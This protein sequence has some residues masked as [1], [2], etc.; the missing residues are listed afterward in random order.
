MTGFLNEAELAELTPS[1]LVAHR[2]P[3]PMQVVSSDEYYPAPQNER[4]REVERR[5]LSIADT[6]GARHG[7]DRRRFFQT[8]AGMTASFLAMNEV[9]GALFDATAA[10]AA[11]PELAQERADSLKD[12]LILDMHT[13][14][15]PM[16]PASRPF[17]TCAKLWDRPA[18]TRS[19]PV[20][21]RRSTT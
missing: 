18:G 16:T 10:E 12:Q 5:L 19:L 9:Y 4:Q 2:T 14:F 1:E 3:V 13:H 15:W 17:S 21:S 7:L 20:K 6:I 8:A 11:T